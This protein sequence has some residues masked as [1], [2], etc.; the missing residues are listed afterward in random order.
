MARRVSRSIDENMAYLKDLMGVGTSFDLILR[1]Y[2]VDGQRYALYYVNGFAQD[3]LIFEVMKQVSAGG[4][5]AAPTRQELERR[6]SYGQVSA[7]NDLD[8]F[9]FQVL[10]G[11]MGLLI[12]GSDEALVMDTR[13]Y[14]D[15]QPEESDTERVL[16]GPRDGFVETLL[17]N[18]A[19]VRRRMRDPRLRF[20]LYQAGQH[21]RMDVAVCYLD[22]F[23]SQD[24]VE[25]VRQSVRR[26]DLAGLTMTEQALMENIHPHPWNPFP[27]VRVTERPDVVAENLLEGRVAIL[28]DTSP[29]VVLAP[30][31]YFSHL[32]HPED[33]HIAPLSGT[34]QRWVSLLALFIGTYVTPI[35]LVLALHPVKALSY[36][37]PSSPPVYSL[38]AQ[39]LFAELG[40]DTVRRAVLN[41]PR[42]I[43]TSMSILA[44]VIV[45][46]LAA[47]AKLFAPEVMV[48][49]AI[50][51]VALFAVPSLQ[52][53]QAHRLV[54]IALL[55]LGG[56]L[57]W[58]G[59]LLGTAALLTLLLSMDSF[60][61]PY[62]WPLLPFD[63]RALTTVLLRRPLTAKDT[64]PR[65]ILRLH[66]QGGGA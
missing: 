29:M 56:A 3:L 31:T 21:T 5:G 22:G 12:D 2:E 15:R 61:L 40:I 28:I 57:G 4:L 49:S 36:I 58:W 8:A 60:G 32:H 65:R 19:L 50:A 1:E 43:A 11:P 38:L 13:S 46:D 17:F 63:F 37:G 44:A 39:F 20:E 34:Y 24:L 42:I 41:A 26:L 48:Y 23:T 6:L 9:A 14:P 47:K 27:V 59:L 10:S 35:W 66:P 33:Y 53:G 64:A 51:A 54:R 55:V 18:C 52:L 25:A 16:M 7:L 30:Y 62:L 45:G